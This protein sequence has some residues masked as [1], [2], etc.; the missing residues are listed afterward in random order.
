MTTSSP[1]R[2][3]TSAMYDTKANDNKSV[4]RQNLCKTADHFN[5]VRDY[6]AN[7][8]TFSSS[9]T[10]FRFDDGD[11]QSDDNIEVSEEWF[12]LLNHL[13]TIMYGL[14]YG[15]LDNG[16]SGNSGVGKTAAW[17][18]HVAA[19]LYCRPYS[20]TSD[21]IVTGTDMHL[22]KLA[23]ELPQAGIGNT[24]KVG[25]STCGDWAKG[26]WANEDDSCRS[27][28]RFTMAQQMY[29][30]YLEQQSLQ[31]VL[32]LTSDTWK[33]NLTA[34]ETA[35]RLDDYGN[36]VSTLSFA[37]RYPDLKHT[38]AS[39]VLSCSGSGDKQTPKDLQ[40]RDKANMDQLVRIQDYMAENVKLSYFF[41]K[42]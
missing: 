28:D 12:F 4:Q 15:Y 19:K 39:S 9:I 2:Q 18:W 34:V 10:P 30:N 5:V 38:R 11:G 32:V 20:Y 35:T 14:H 40:P 36:A 31:A 3:Q 21:D 37:A 42:S 27:E 25:R 22:S 29:V 23:N 26:Q 41:I 8:N 7:Q 6:S 24:C 16:E 17:N 13:K 1:V 33:K